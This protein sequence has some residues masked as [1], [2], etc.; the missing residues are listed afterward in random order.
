MSRSITSVPGWETFAEQHLLKKYAQAVPSGGHILEIGSEHGMSA[1]ILRTYSPRDAMITCVEP[2]LNAM[3]EQNLREAN[4]FYNLTW[5]K[6]TSDAFFKAHGDLQFDLIFIDG[7]HHYEQ[8]LRDIEHA[9]DAIK[10]TGTIILHDVAVQTN[11]QPH[12][13]HF[14]VLFAL[15]KMITIRPAFH[16]IETVDSCA[17]VQSRR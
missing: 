1:S 17:V 11:T 13:Q 2:D 8:V 10:D 6:D 7:D 3:F 5:F 9:F 14:E 4:L 16:V 12:P 15:R